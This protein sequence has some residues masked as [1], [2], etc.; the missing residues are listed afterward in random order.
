MRRVL[1]KKI[2]K[3]DFYEV[4]IVGHKKF[5]AL[6]FPFYG[7]LFIPLYLRQAFEI[8]SVSVILLQIIILYSYIHQRFP[9]CHF[10]FQNFRLKCTSF[11]ICRI[12]FLFKI[13]CFLDSHIKKLRTMLSCIVTTDHWVT[14]GW[15]A[16]CHS[17]CIF[18]CSSSCSG[19][20]F[21]CCCGSFHGK[22]FKV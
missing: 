11:L 12:F 16:W 18:T 2:N 4:S 14:P 19:S 21:I 15:C 9:F 6:F 20:A 10:W 3:V 7:P 8:C 17:K 5:I 22:R 13:S 1:K